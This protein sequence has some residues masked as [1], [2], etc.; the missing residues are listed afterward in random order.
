V[1]DDLRRRLRLRAGNALLQ[2]RQVPGDQA[3]GPSVCDG[4][5]VRLE[6]LR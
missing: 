1:Q 4:S 6:E 5:R 2:R 3:H